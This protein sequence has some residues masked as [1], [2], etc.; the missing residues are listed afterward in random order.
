MN[1]ILETGKCLVILGKLIRPFNNKGDKIELDNYRGT[2]MV[3]IGSKL[4]CMILL[5]PRDPV[6]EV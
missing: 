6:N 3:S 2:A 4:F 1:M 5:R